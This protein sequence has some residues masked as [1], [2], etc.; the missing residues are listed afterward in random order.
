M[1]ELLFVERGGEILE[2]QLQDDILDSGQIGFVKEDGKESK[3]KRHK[4]VPKVR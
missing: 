3:G 1:E 4:M 2:I